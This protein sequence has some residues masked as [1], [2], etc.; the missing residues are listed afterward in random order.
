M[1]EE[2]ITRA[3]SGMITTD[4]QHKALIDAGVTDIGLHRGQ[5]FIL[6]QIAET[7]KLVSQKEI[8][9]RFHISQAAVTFALHKLEGDGYI[10]RS[11][12]EDSRYNRIEI[13]EKGRD[14]VERSRRLFHETDR[15]LF[16]GFDEEELKTYIACLEK[17]RNNMESYRQR[18][19][20]ERK[21]D[22]K[23]V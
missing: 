7:G 3:I 8:A 16:E 23:M 11:R 10:S 13:T 6:M 4:R 2:L 15:H 17:I 12:G 1:K 14:M 19:A 9:E 5:H 18:T 21:K 20:A 22:E